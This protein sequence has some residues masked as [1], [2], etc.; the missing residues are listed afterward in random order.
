MIFNRGA[1]SVNAFTKTCC[2]GMQVVSVSFAG[3]PG[4]SIMSA[5]G[6]IN[7]VKCDNAVAVAQAVFIMSDKKYHLAA[8]CQFG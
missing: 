5:S 3:K 7:L 8:L 4:V 6:F 1:T 2:G